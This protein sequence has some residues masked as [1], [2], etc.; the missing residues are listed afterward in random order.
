M[1]SAETPIALGL[2]LILLPLPRFY[3]SRVRLRTIAYLDI[4]RRNAS[5][6]KVWT[7]VLTMPW[8]WIELVRAVVGM[9]CL[10]TGLEALRLRGTY[11]AFSAPWMVGALALGIGLLAIP[12]A[13]P[14]TRSLKGT[15][16]PITFVAGALIIVLPWH[17][18]L[19]ALALGFVALLSFKSLAAFFLALSMALAGFAFFFANMMFAGAVATV[20][21]ALP[22]LFAFFSERELVIAMRSSRSGG[23]D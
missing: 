22:M 2:L 1:D 6:G 9:W 17:A 16:A 7:R 14:R 10:T 20:F 13:L 3:A 23:G 12:V 5:W 21:A 15:I 11:H 19:G 18:S 4:E 8:H